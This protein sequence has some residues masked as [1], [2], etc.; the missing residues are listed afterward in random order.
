[1][2]LC[3]VS[4][5]GESIGKACGMNVMLP[6]EG[7]GPFA[8]LYLLHGLSDDYTIWQR[9]T[10]V[11][12]YAADHGLIV[13]TPDGHRSFYCNDPRPGGMAY[14]D[15]I[16]KDV[17]GFVD[18]WFPTV[19]QRRGRAIAGLSMG[20]YG[21]M[22]LALRHPD[23][24]AA[25]SSHSSAFGFAHEQRGRAGIDDL[26]AAL[27][28]GE[29]D[30]FTLAEKLQAA[31]GDLAIRFDCGTEDGLLEGNRAF[32][33]HLDAIGVAHGYAEYPGEH[34]WAYWDEHVQE[35]LAFVAGHVSAGA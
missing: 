1:M 19:P 23:M 28:E 6:D 11:E 10:S 29:Y 5:R 4:F 2:S 9:R 3:N 12:R 14:E 33:A 34:N 26:A 25:V 8:V 17:V 32:H 22:M 18:K 15:H 16:V 7:D 24:F 21:S 35:T 30:C 31:G 27:P 20:G 13:V